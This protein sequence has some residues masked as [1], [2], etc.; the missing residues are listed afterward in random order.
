M[1]FLEGEGLRYRRVEEVGGW[2]VE[3]ETV[4]GFDL[5]DAL[6][7][8]SKSATI[9]GSVR[10]CSVALHQRGIKVTSQPQIMLLILSL[11]HCHGNHPERKTKRNHKVTP[12][13]TVNEAF[14]IVH[15]HTTT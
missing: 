1:R 3:V 9:Q 10:Q 12:L 13:G 15:R 5:G 4:S 8:F 11:T 7:V 14:I 6:V 2:K